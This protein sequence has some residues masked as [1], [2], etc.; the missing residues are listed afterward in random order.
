MSTTGRGVQSQC[1]GGTGVNMDKA[2]LSTDTAGC[3]D[4]LEE[5]TDA[6]TY[7]THRDVVEPLDSPLSVSLQSAMAKRQLDPAQWSPGQALR[8][9]DQGTEFCHME[10]FHSPLI[11]SYSSQ[12][13]RWKVTGYGKI[14]QVSYLI[15]LA[16]TN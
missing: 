13:D 14:W 7:C 2:S 8:S 1:S 4:V 5:F 3:V 9:S 11:S 16:E 6:D 15:L 12:R 10:T